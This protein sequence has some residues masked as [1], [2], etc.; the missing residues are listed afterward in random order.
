MF[1][2]LGFVDEWQDPRTL[3]LVCMSFMDFPDLSVS[4]HIMYHVIFHVLHYT[5]HVSCHFSCL[6]LYKSCIMPLL[7]SYIKHTIHTIYCITTHVLY[8]THV[9]YRYSC[10]T[11]HI[12]CIMSLLMQLISWSSNESQ[13]LNL[14]IGHCESSPNNGCWC[15]MSTGMGT[16]LQI[17]TIE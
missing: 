11:L 8:C 16:F 2:P 10:L 9:S 3:K 17:L 15:D 6:T 12:S 14:K 5:N 4:T 1:V 13:W 7:M